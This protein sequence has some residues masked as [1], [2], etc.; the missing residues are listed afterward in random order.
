MDYH[1]WDTTAEKLFLIF[2]STGNAVLPIFCSAHFGWRDICCQVD[3]LLFDTFVLARGHFVTARLQSLLPKCNYWKVLNCNWKSD[4]SDSRLKGGT[5]CNNL[6]SNYVILWNF[7]CCNVAGVQYFCQLPDGGG[8]CQLSDGRGFCQT[9]I[10]PLHL[11]EHRSLPIPRKGGDSSP[12]HFSH[13]C[14]LKFTFWDVNTVW[15]IVQIL[16]L[17]LSRFH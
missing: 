17:H 8:F 1:W 12:P 10:P 4:C 6:Q 3:L 16:C 5:V 2:L 7:Y 13:M 9:L 14:R 15:G 11:D